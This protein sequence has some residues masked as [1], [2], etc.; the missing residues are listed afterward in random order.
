MVED[1][2]YRWRGPATDEAHAVVLARAE[3]SSDGW[4][5]DG[6]VACRVVEL[7]EFLPV[8]HECVEQAS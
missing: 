3:A 8:A 2:T 4:N 1:G 5:P 6:P 7:A